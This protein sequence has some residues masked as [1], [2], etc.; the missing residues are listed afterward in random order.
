MSE[1]GPY[2][3]DYHQQEACINKRNIID[4]DSHSNYHPHFQGM[5]SN[6]SFV[7]LCQ[8]ATY[9]RYRLLVVEAQIMDLT[10]G[11]YTPQLRTY[12]LVHTSPPGLMHP[13]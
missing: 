10:I 11:I 3:N 2:I 8:E 4:R 5:Q 12:A 6:A 9:L 13:G 7:Q 1:V